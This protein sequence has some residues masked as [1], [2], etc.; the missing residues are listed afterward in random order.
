MAGYGAARP[1][2]GGVSVD[3]E[4]V[5]AARTEATKIKETAERL[6]NGD[7]PEGA[8]HIRVLAGMIHQLAEQVE[9]LASQM[10]ESTSGSD[11]ARFEPSVEPSD[12]AGEGLEEDITPERA[13]AQP[14]DDRSSG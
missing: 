1:I 12:E 13:P 9:R 14:A 2:E 5:E 6:A 4:E 10:S 11:Q 7:S 3:R 8:D